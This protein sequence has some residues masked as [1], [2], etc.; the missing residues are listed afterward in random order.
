MKPYTLITGASTGFGKSLAI[1]FAQQ[2]MN[3]VIVALPNSG[4]LE[5]GAFLKSNFEINV[6]ALEMDLSNKENCLALYES[7]KAHNASIKYLINNAGVLS[8]GYFEDLQEDY[9]LTQIGVNVTAPTLLTKLFIEDF[10]TNAPSGILNVSS[11]ASFFNMPKKQVYSGTKAYLLSFSKS[12]RKEI[13]KYGI[14]VSVVCPG[15]MNTTTGL[16][17]QNRRLGWLPR[18]SILDPEDAAKETLK[19][20]FMKQELIVP[21]KMNKVFMFLDTIVPRAIKSRLTANVV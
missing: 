19:R 17:M 6:I 18:T 5:L 1:E 20:F 15:G 11:M 21:G 14:W 10:K 2:G 7:V 13:G 8:K 16:C 4:L 9:M 12:L 3:L